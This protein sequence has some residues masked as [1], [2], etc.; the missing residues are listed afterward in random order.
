MF[1]FVR[2]IAVIQPKLP[3]QRL[4]Q[5]RLLLCCL[6]GCGAPA[7]VGAASGAP[8]GDALALLNAHR[9]QVRQLPAAQDVTNIDPR[10]TSRSAGHAPAHRSA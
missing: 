6:A 4:L 3:T 8:L 7:A 5:R 10:Y 1:S 9:H 2:N